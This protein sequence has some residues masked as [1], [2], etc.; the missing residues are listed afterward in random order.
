MPLR[1][2]RGASAPTAST[3]LSTGIDSPVRAA[4]STRRSRAVTSR[5]SAG[6]LSPETIATTSPGTRSAASIS[7]LRPPR[8]TVAWGDSRA[9]IAS[10]ADSA[11]PSWMKPMSALTS[12]AAT[13]TPVSI[14]WPSAA[15]TAAEPSI[16]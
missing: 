2:P 5:R 15:V 1:S 14:Q 10:S 16:T 8:T 11:L 9:R 12:T 6:T 7:R 3:P 4:S 13:S